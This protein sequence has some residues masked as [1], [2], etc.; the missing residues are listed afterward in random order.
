ME[1]LVSKSIVFYQCFLHALP[2]LN[3]YSKSRELSFTQT[4]SGSP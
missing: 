3:A 2:Y 4:L 1:V